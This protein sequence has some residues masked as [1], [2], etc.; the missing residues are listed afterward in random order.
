VRNNLANATDPSGL[1]ASIWNLN[2]IF[3]AIWQKLQMYNLD[4]QLALLKLQQI[5]K[6]GVYIDTPTANPATGD[7]NP[8]DGKNG[9]I[10]WVGEWHLT[11]N[12]LIGFVVQEVYQT[13]TVPGNP[14]FSAQKS[15]HY[16]EAFPYDG[17]SFPLGEYDNYWTPA[18]PRGKTGTV[19]FAGFATFVPAPIAVVA[20]LKNAVMKN[21]QWMG[22]PW[23][24]D[25]ASPAGQI[26]FTTT[27]PAGW[28]NLPKIEHNLAV[29]VGAGGQATITYRIPR[30]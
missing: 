27:K 13:V 22:A 8:S 1:Q 24:R 3:D 4:F 23:T 30:F 6:A 7:D 16:W 18:L 14:V 15:K 26:P 28:D 12:T 19:T 2:P 29:E 5:Q 10:W 25:P 21:V 17:T 20:S 11:N 9:R